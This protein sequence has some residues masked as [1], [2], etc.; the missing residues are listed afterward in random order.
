MNIINQALETV[1]IDAVRP[2]PENPRRGDVA[3]IT[4]SIKHN[5]FVGSLIVQRSSGHILAGT[6]RWKA[7]QAAGLKEV[8]VMWVDVNNDHARRILLADNRTSD[9]ADYD[10]ASLIELLKRASEETGLDGTVY[11]DD[12]L[13]DLIA[14]AEEVE[15]APQ[16]LPKLSSGG[17]GGG[18]S[19]NVTVYT[20]NPEA[21]Q[22]LIE[23]LEEEGYECKTH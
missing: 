7:A 6:H 22:T 23:M 3:A 5:G 11:T 8:P 9:K 19:Y 10:D 21:Q 20:G 4:D 13:N 16:K 17:G 14:R 2:H 12:D 15:E 18:V 1:P